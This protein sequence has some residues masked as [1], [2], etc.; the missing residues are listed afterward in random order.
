MKGYFHILKFALSPF[1]QGIY[2]TMQGLEILPN[3]SLLF[4]FVRI[5]LHVF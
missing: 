1:L 2:N 4:A 3:L 5:L